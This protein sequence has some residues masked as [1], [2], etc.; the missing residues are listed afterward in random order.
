LAEHGVHAGL[1]YPVAAHR[2]PVHAQRFAGRS[3]HVAERLA[4]EVLTLPLSHEHTDDEIARVVD[5]VR[6]YY[7]S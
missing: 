2:Q 5:V 1:H 3:F 6:W 7:R 4:D